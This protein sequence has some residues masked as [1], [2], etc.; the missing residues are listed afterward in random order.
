MKLKN[1]NVV[2]LNPQEVQE[3]EGGWGVVIGALLGTALTQDLDK[4]VDAYNEGY[5]NGYNSTHTG[6]GGS[7]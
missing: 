7:W 3:T 5:A 6:A 2:E 1:L 4:L